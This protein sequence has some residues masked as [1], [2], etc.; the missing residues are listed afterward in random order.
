MIAMD[1]KRIPDRAPRKSR[2]RARHKPDP[3]RFNAFKLSLPLSPKTG[4]LKRILNSHTAVAALIAA[5][6]LGGAFRPRQGRDRMAED[7]TFVMEEEIPAAAPQPPPPPPD[8]TP[9]PK[10][11]EPPEPLPPPQFGLEEDAMGEGGDMAVAAGNTVMKEAEAEVKPA[12]PPLPAAPVFI[13]QAP[14]I[15]SG[16]APDYPGRALD[17]GLEATVTALITIDTLGRVTNVSIEK[18]GGTDFDQAV[19][20][21]ARTTLFQPP[22]RQGRKAPTRFRRPYEFK[23]EE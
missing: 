22:V 11:I 21:S 14:R 7:E 17:R 4:H 9:P 10:A 6:V 1:P 16:Q 18:S 15:L 19:L 8:P 12:P 2:N 13:D 23:L 5:G 3:G 20:K